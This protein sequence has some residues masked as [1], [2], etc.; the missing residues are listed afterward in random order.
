MN[1]T[2]RDALKYTFNGNQRLLIYSGS[3]ENAEDY[4]KNFSL[5]VSIN[6][7]IYNYSSSW[8]PIRLGCQQRIY[9]INITKYFEKMYGN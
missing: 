4:C 7:L 2:I 5:E 1:F 8:E 6:G 9:D 3:E